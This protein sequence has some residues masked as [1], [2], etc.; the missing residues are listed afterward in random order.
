MTKEMIFS[1]FKKLQTNSEKIQY[2][3]FLMGLKLHHLDIN[4][5]NLLKYYRSKG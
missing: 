1:D 2:I 3:E 4:Y 5:E